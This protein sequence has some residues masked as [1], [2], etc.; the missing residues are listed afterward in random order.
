M[1]RARAVVWEYEPIVPSR[2]ES[3]VNIDGRSLYG[4]HENFA[5]V[6]ADT[7][8]KDVPVEMSTG[9]PV[10][11][12]KGIRQPDAHTFNLTSELA[13]VDGVFP[14]WFRVYLMNQTQKAVET[15]HE[16][17]GFANAVGVAYSLYA[18]LDDAWLW[19]Q[20]LVDVDAVARP[21]EED[22]TTVDPLRI[23]ADAAHDPYW[24]WPPNVWSHQD[25]LMTST[26]NLS[27][28]AERTW[29][30]TGLPLLGTCTWNGNRLFAQIR[31]E[32][33]VEEDTGIDLY[34]YCHFNEWWVRVVYVTKPT[35]CP[36]PA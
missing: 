4:F 26:W 2:T 18:H 14:E 23:Q 19:V 35:T 1:L 36:P 16:A 27:E 24:V 10:R 6:F 33:N 34:S 22:G 28:E 11:M 17:G 15:I 12:Y 13:R 3:H 25:R 8:G 7:T 21:C 20:S 5:E 29:N 30:E 32:C 31:A 9:H